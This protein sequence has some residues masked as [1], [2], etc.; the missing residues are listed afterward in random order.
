MRIDHIWT[1]IIGSSDRFS[2]TNF[3]FDFFPYICLLIKLRSNKVNIIFVQ[4]KL[5]A[6]GHGPPNNN[7]ILITLQRKRGVCVR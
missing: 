2:T 1:V 5:C 6:E 3:S 7:N 4:P